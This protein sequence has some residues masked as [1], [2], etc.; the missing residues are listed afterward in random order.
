MC[1]LRGVSAVTVFPFRTYYGQTESPTA[2][3]TSPPPFSEQVLIVDDDPETREWC[4]E[5]LRGEGYRVVSAESG[6]SAE[7]VLRSSAVDVTVVDLRMPQMG[8][9]DVLRVAKEAD[10]DTVV[11]LIT[12]FPT[13]DTAVEAMKFG[14]AEYLSSGTPSRRGGAGKHTASC[15][16]GCA[17]ASPRAASWG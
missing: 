17:A 4:A 5:V 1:E 6:R 15:G 14:A 3:P 8:G 10:P 7:A 12:A 11:I 16:A 13:V 2:K 9:L